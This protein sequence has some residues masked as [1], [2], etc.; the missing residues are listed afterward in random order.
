MNRFTYYRPTASRCMFDHNLLNWNSSRFGAGGWGYRVNIKGWIIYPHVHR[1]QSTTVAFTPNTT[2]KEQQQKVRGNRQWAPAAAPSLRGSPVPMQLGLAAPSTRP[3]TASLFLFW[4][5]SLTRLH[6]TLF[7]A[8][9]ADI[10]SP[11]SPRR[12]SFHVGD[13]NNH[14]NQ[15]FECPPAR[16]VPRPAAA[17]PGSAPLFPQDPERHVNKSISKT[18]QSSSYSQVASSVR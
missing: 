7:V 14:S 3:F 12:A 11:S 1:G 15:N 8:L 5:T 13:V 17:A 6:P 9:L 4:D 18:V 16:S 2:V 10:L